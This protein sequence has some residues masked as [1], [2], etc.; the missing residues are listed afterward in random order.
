MAWSESRIENQKEDSSLQIP[1]VA[2]QDEHCFLLFWFLWWSPPRW[3]RVCTAMYFLQCAYHP[4]FF[5][6]NSAT[7]SPFLSQ[8]NVNQITSK[9]QC[10]AQSIKSNFR[11]EKT[12]FLQG[13]VH[14]QEVD[15][16]NGITVQL[17]EYAVMSI[18]RWFDLYLLCSEEQWPYWFNNFFLHFQNAKVSEAYLVTACQFCY[19]G[20]LFLLDKC[21]LSH[22]TNTVFSW[23][24][25]T[26][27]SAKKKIRCNVC[28]ESSSAIAE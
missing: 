22:F 9:T 8:T 24:E 15:Y 17:I 27:K 4:C 23:T 5:S 20:S 2:Q 13:N 25:E 10:L 12:R 28:N 18:C 1:P 14:L 21:K 6:C 7:V 3:D 16:C 11:M 26:L 19:S